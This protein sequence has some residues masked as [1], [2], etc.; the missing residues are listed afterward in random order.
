MKKLF[1][2]FFL[3]ISTAFTQQEKVTPLLQTKILHSKENEQLL[4]WVFFSD[5]GNA[6]EQYFAHPSVVVSEKSLHRR[7]KVLP[8]NALIDITDIPVNNS[9]ISA[10]QQFGFALKQKSKWFNGISGYVSKMQIQQIASLPFVK[11]ID[12]VYQLHKP[13]EIIPA[14]QEIILPQEKQTH[15]LDYGASFTQVNQINVPP[16]HDLGIHGEGV[17]VCLMD[18]GFNNLPHESFAQMNIIAKYDF[19]NHD[20]GVGDST[21][22]GEGSH[23]TQTLSTIGGYKPGQLIGPAFGATYILAKT[24]NTDSETPIEEDNWIAASEW[25]DSIGVDVTSTSLGYITFDSP[26]T[27]Y[28]W[29]NMDGNTCRIT[30][31]ADM[32]VLK[33]IT[34][35]NSAGNEGDNSSHNTL[36]APADGD[37][38]IAIG[39]VNSDGSRSSFSSVGPSVDGRIKPDVMAMGS[40]VRVASPTSTTGYTSSSGTS[41][42]CPLS[43][44]VAALVLSAN[45]TLSPMQV[46]D[47]MRNT[48]SRHNSPDNKFGYG[49][50][51]ALDAI[52]FFRVQISHS[53]LRDTENPARA[54]KVTAQLTS[55]LALDSTKLFVFYSV[56]STTQFDSILF[57]YAGEDLY[58]VN[59]PVSSNNVTVRYYI[60]AANSVGVFSYMPLDALTGEYF[61]FYVGADIV[62][63]VITH[64]RLG[65]QSLLAW[66]PKISAKVTDNL[67][68][69]YVYASYLI[70]GIPK[71]DF[72]LA[73]VAT[74]DKYEAYFP[75]PDST[76][77]LGDVIS[78]RIGASDSALISNIGIVPS[79]STY[80]TFEIVSLV[81]YAANFDETNGNI[82]ATNDWEWGIPSTPSPLPN[83]PPKLWGTVLDG[84]YNDG[85]LLS[86][87]ET[88]ELQVFGTSPTF[89]FSHWYEIEDRWDGGNV[90]M[91]VNGGTFAIITPV[92]GY[93]TTI[94]STANN[95]LVNERVFTNISNGWEQVTFNL[96]GLVN[97]G[98]LIKFQFQFG[99]DG[100]ITK[101]GWYID[102]IESNGLGWIPNSV[103][104]N[105]NSPAD[106]SLEQN[107]PNPFNPLT[108]I[109]YTLSTA[110]LVSLKVY[111]ILGRE[112]ATLINNEPMQP[113]KHEVQFDASKLSGGVY[114]YR[115]N[116]DGK[117]SAIKKLVLL[118]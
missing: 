110:A 17:L 89:S 52:N 116:V 71:M 95:P 35:L 31:G 4:V 51:N 99:V 64:T 15:A 38:V 29:Q 69:K 46:R 79:D 3:L 19:V 21:D 59:I 106:F 115:L 58:Q 93:D 11:Q 9:Y 83:S 40:S 53:P 103:A 102:D 16:V 94:R 23:G 50:L 74:T 88:P 48:A 2:L 14:A 86:I 20:S 56:N 81:N 97:S 80:Y 105:N 41:F 7:S 100:S 33:G 70:N 27:S 108:T 68:V 75:I 47:A 25:A 28:T 113:G 32:A 43:A 10:L 1:F 73:K 91:S 109:H 98:D 84:E 96:E 13:K 55:H 112:V 30:I 90:K 12:I 60:K 22:M 24:E 101:P 54:H 92:G 85:P 77:M 37:S 76:V 72:Q 57:T 8:P 117:F 5:K 62:Q 42:S 87:M 66:P 39:A 6:T 26:F 36:G 118:K 45:P 61:Q 49:I 65:A 44:G 104:D 107:Y 82:S 114:F 78:Y 34:V 18:A 67:S 63:P 111:D